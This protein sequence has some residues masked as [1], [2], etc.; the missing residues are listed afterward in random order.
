M[1]LFG[2]ISYN[3]GGVIYKSDLIAKNDVEK[4]YFMYILIGIGILIFI[5]LITIAIILIKNKR[6]KGKAINF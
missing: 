6:N 4:S 3:I 5:I 1:I 2:N